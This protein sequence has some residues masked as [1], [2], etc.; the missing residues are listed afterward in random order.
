MNKR[1]Q[2]PVPKQMCFVVEMRI[3]LL[4]KRP[5][6]HT[7]QNV[8]IVGHWKKV[9]KSSSRVKYPCSA[10]TKVNIS[11]VISFTASIS[12]PKVTLLLDN[13]HPVDVIVDTGA[14]V[15]FLD[16]VD[17]TACGFKNALNPVSQI[18][19]NFDDSRIH[20]LGC[21][22]SVSTKFN[23]QSALYAFYVAQVPCSI[24][25]MDVICALQLTIS[26]KNTLCTPLIPKV[27]E[28]RE[29]NSM[30]IR[31][32]SDALST[33]ITPVRRLPFTLEEPVE[34]ELRK[35]LAA[36]I[37]EPIMTSSYISPIVITTKKDN[38][39]RLC[40]DYR[41]I[42]SC[43]ILDQYPIPSVN[44]LFRKVRNAR[45]FSRI[46]LKFAYYQLDLHPD[47]RHLSAF[48]THVGL[49]Q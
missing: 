31:L 21:V 1:H 17:Y 9:C 19:D 32:K 27:C 3:T 42:N 2:K 26:C 38:S 22:S 36:D 45:V 49:F 4:R 7:M 10:N 30:T 15:S 41:R 33:I 14:D 28:I 23:N 25:G 24:I 43:T 47:S 6:Q 39:I 35:L 18:F 12:R 13:R 11:S 20:L 37:I 48:I 16:T 29:D 40:A 8:A 5:V 44:E 46:D 34:H